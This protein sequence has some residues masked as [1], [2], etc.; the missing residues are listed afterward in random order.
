[1]WGPPEASLSPAPRPP[2]PGLGNSWAAVEAPRPGASNAH[3]RFPGSLR[4][5][6][7]ASSHLPPG[8]VGE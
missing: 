5:A 6:L 2:V 1:M 8:W 4:P 7:L 3:P